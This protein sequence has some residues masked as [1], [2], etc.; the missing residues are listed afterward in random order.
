MSMRGAWRVVAVAS[1]SA[2]A[3]VLSGCGLLQPRDGEESLEAQEQ[4]IIGVDDGRERSTTSTSSSTTSTLPTAPETDPQVRTPDSE[5]IEV[6]TPLPDQLVVD[7]SKF[8]ADDPS[9]F[10]AIPEPLDLPRSAVFPN[11]PEFCATGVRVTEMGDQVW[12]LPAGTSVERTRYELRSLLN[13]VGRAV[14]L[15]PVE[16]SLFADQVRWAVIRE[17][18]GFNSIDT[19]EDFQVLV[20]R[21]VARHPTFEPALEG[22]SR[23]CD[24]SAVFTLNLRR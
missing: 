4:L 7:P 19:P 15:A 9:L 8:V 12:D 5:E 20:E 1:L 11:A 10:P 17:S 6:P 22:M 14:A 3:V 21:L 2:V 24:E 16:V 13:E 23:F 18:D